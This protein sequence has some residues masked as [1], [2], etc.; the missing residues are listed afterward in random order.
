MLVRVLAVRL[1]LDK[2][3]HEMMGDQLN[4]HVFVY[5]KPNR[6]LDALDMHLTHVRELITL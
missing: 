5:L 1:F 2:I 4:T 6:E 3:R